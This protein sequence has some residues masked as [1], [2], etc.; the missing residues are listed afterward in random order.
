MTKK[1]DR[2]SIMIDNNMIKKIRVIQSH[3]IKQSKKNVSFSHIVDELLKNG[4]K[5]IKH[6]SLSLIVHTAMISGIFTGI[7]LNHGIRHS[8]HSIDSLI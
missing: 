7:C 5:N 8:F 1:L 6:K 3:R 4:L 2:I